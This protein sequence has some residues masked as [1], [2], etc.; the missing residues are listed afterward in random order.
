MSGIAPNVLTQ[1]VRALERN[2]Q[3]DRPALLRAPTTIVYEL[4][5]AGSELAPR[6]GCSPAGARATRRSP[7]GRATRSAVRRRQAVWWC[8]RVTAGV[9]RRGRGPALRVIR[10][11]VWSRHRSDTARSPRRS[12]PASGRREMAGRRSTPSPGSRSPKPPRPGPS[13]DPTARSAARDRSLTTHGASAKK[14]GLWARPAPQ[15]RLVLR[16]R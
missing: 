8:Q 2:A 14:S 4:S 16:H 6:C 1:R 13:A 11:A 9:R 12:W 10:W 5:A 3:R 15:R 7:P